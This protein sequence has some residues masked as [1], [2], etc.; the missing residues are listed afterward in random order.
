MNLEQFIE[1]INT[2]PES[3]EFKDT[4]AMIEGNYYYT[5]G[6]FINDTLVNETGTNEGSCKIFFFARLHD[7]AAMQTLACFG[8]YYREDVLLNPFSD[9]HKNIRN[10][11]KTGWTGITFKNEILE[12]KN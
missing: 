7:L 5:P 6:T 10:F 2:S 1:K 3:I 8:K 12:K 4:I 9:S 11:M